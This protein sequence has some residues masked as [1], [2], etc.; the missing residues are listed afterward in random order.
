[1][2]YIKTLA[3]ILPAPEETFMHV[4]VTTSA[5]LIRCPDNTS[6]L[7]RAYPGAHFIRHAFPSRSAAASYAD[8]AAK[9]GYIA[10]AMTLDATYQP[11]SKPL[12]PVSDAPTNASED[13]ARF[14]YQP[15]PAEQ[16]SPEEIKAAFGHVAYWKQEYRRLLNLVRGGVSAERERRLRILMEEALNNIAVY[17]SN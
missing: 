16:A 3:G 4:H 12:T 5:E 14:N 8:I 9:H 10:A 6:Y 13:T 1:L 7:V 2:C 17:A 15:K 11:E